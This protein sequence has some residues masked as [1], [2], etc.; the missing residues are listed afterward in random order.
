MGDAR[1]CSSVLSRMSRPCQQGGE[2]GH[3]PLGAAQEDMAPAGLPLAQRGG[4]GHPRGRGL[5]YKGAQKQK[6]Q[7]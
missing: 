4:M 2:E 6:Q 3:D 1:A 7:A 5:C